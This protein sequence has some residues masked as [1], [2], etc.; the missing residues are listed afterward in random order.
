M[1]GGFSGLASEAAGCRESVGSQKGRACRF[2]LRNQHRICVAPST[3]S[4]PS[5]FKGAPQP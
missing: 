3:P 1:R 2:K 4:L 5:P